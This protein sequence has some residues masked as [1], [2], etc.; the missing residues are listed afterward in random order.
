MYSLARHGYG[1]I[2]HGTRQTVSRLWLRNGT[3]KM[4]STRLDEIVPNNNDAPPPL[5]VGILR[6]TYNPWERRAPLTPENVRN[7]LSSRPGA[8]IVV[9]P[10]HFRIFSNQD[11]EQAGALVQDDLSSCD[12]ILG[13]KR[14]RTWPEFQPPHNK[15]NPSYLVFSHVVKGQPENME[16]LQQALERQIPF[17]DYECILNRVVVE[18]PEH[19]K[20]PKPQRLVA[21]GKYAGLAGMLDTWSVLGRRL[22]LQGFSTPFLNV[23]PSI[24]HP[25][26]QHAK[27]AVTEMGQMIATEGLP[28]E[29]DPVIVAMT[30]PGGKVHQGVRE[31]F[32]LVPNEMVSVHD[33]PQVLKEQS[34]SDQPCYKVYGVAPEMSELYQHIAGQP[35]ERDDFQQ[36]P[37]NYTSLFSRQVAPFISVLMNCV[38]WDERF[39]RLLTRQDMQYLYQSQQDR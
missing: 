22:L 15:K 10:C 1:S 33:L 35:F 29:M 2:H 7:F 5:T 8:Q 32:D 24:Y 34:R 6:E 25:D 27:D 39:P 11:Y 14:P 28:A 31:I 37:Q 21:F 18:E 36:N 26:L 13:V 12:L 17:L 19:A 23:P 38:Y 9:Q 16:L 3:I 30:A 20:P 4:F